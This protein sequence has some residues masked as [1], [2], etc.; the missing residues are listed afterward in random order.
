MLPQGCTDIHGH[1]RCQH[2]TGSRL[3]TSTPRD[4]PP[5]GRESGRRGDQRL[6]TIGGDP[7][8][9]LVRRPRA[10]QVGVELELATA[11]A[12]LFVRVAGT[13]SSMQSI[14]DALLDVLCQ[15]TWEQI[16]DDHRRVQLVWREDLGP[17]SG[18]PRYV[19]KV[20]AELGDA[21]VIALAQR[22]VEAFSERAGITV[23]NALWDHEAGGR[24]EISVITRRKLCAWFEGKRLHPEEGATMF[25]ARFAIAARGIPNI[26][27]DEG[28]RLF[29]HPPHV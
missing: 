15:G 14:R 16:A 9:R 27:Y 7:S 10:E 8:P 29:A 3:V 5:G 1:G 22:C 17:R 19:K 28:G 18:K 11:D 4:A 26:D 12:I 24:L 20:L 2:T 23:Q 13:L 21:E 6:A 25:L